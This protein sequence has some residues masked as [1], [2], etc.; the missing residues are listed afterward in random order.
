MKRRGFLFGFLGLCG[1]GGAAA[2]QAKPQINTEVAPARGVKFMVQPTYRGK[3]VA[4][5]HR[6]EIPPG[7]RKFVIEHNLDSPF[8]T[9]QFFTDE[10][11]NVVPDYRLLDNNRVEVR[12]F[13]PSLRKYIAAIVG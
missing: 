9:A 1:V 7:T 13:E 10:G 4:C 3:K 12:F 6:Q 8:V 5:V 2:K 11:D